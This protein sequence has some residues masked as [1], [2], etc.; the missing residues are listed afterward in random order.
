MLRPLWPVALFA[1]ALLAAPVH[2]QVKL[3]WKLHEKDTFRVKT[4]TVLKSEMDIGG[5]KDGMDIKLARV[6]RY[7]V[8]KRTASVTVLL[9]TIEQMQGLIGDERIEAFLK[10][11]PG[12]TFV[13]TL[14]AKGQVLRVAGYEDFVKRLAGDNAKDED[15][16]RKKL[17][18]GAVVA[19]VGAPFIAF[20]EGPVS[21]GDTWTTTSA[22]PIGRLGDLKTV[23]TFTYQGRKAEG[24]VITVAPRSTFTPV[25]SPDP[26]VRILKG[27]FETKSRG[28]FI[29]FDSEK[30]RLVRVR[31]PLTHEGTLVLQVKGERGEMKMR[32]TQD[33]GAVVLDGAADTV[34]EPKK[35]PRGD[36]DLIQGTWRI[37][38]L[39]AD[40]RPE[41]EA[42]YVGNTFTFR[43]NKAFLKEGKHPPIEFGF[44]LDPSATPR[45]ID[46]SA[47]TKILPGIY[48][49]KGDELRLCLS[50]EDRPTDFITRR[51]DKHE[52]FVLQ[53][54]KAK[55]D[56]VLWKRFTAKKHGFSVELPGPEAPEE[57]VRRQETPLGPVQVSIFVRRNPAERFSYLVQSYRL[58]QR[59]RP[60][61]VAQVLDASRDAVVRELAG[62]GGKLD[63]EKVYKE[64]GRVSRDLQ[65]SVGAEGRGRVRM[66]LLGDRL[67][68]LMVVGVREAA[69]SP[70][71]ERF[72]RSFRSEAE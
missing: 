54:V 49:L 42:N 34:A 16:V 26:G 40:G 69:T 35:G 39:E 65:I 14:D 64:D 29:V 18:E 56:V 1:G 30:G 41:K 4:V 58:P 45:T 57:R 72:W 46:L 52:L 55:E 25:K 50:L 24:D 66:F 2:G 63:S 62:K 27:T 15:W 38:R 20:P 28:G 33:I 12:A 21:P 7:V 22:T 32:M 48:Q 37:V 61:E 68:M 5:R 13:L 53:R 47:R 23:S 60:G 17:S 9:V 70:S 31:L 19:S 67:Y 71:V 59:P 10:K 36:R 44:E 3:A 11:A 6:D 51:G 43:G 8:R